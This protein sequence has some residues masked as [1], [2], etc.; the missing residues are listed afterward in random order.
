MFQEY[1]YCVNWGKNYYWELSK[2]CSPFQKND[3]PHGSATMGL[4]CLWPLLWI[5]DC[6]ALSDVPSFR[7]VVGCFKVGTA[8][9]LVWPMKCE[10][11]CVTSGG[12]FTN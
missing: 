10:E 9:M 8:I 7:H 2:S 6:R 1:S 11:I 3:T 12:G 5:M 4:W